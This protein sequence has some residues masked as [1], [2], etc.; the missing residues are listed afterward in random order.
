MS[1]RDEFTFCP[2]CATRLEEKLHL[3]EMRPVCPVCGWVH[4]LDPKVACAAL[5]VQEG[6]VLLVRRSM[7]PH[8]GL[9]S[10]PAGFMNA[11]ERAEEAVVR[12]VRE[13][14]GLETRVERLFDLFSGREHPRGAD[15]FLVYLVWQTGGTL[16]AGDDASEAAWFPLDQLPGLA[17][18]STQKIL[19]AARS[20]S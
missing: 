15:L 19:S 4:Y 6:R 3:G 16:A 1:H 10:L 9:W 13:E 18:A 2:Q 8:R 12:E 11:Y 7:Q 17:F 5:L 14:T 20:L